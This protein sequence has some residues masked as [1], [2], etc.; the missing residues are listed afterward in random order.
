MEGRCHHFCG[1]ILKRRR[2]RG[3]E[4]R[5]KETPYQ[6]SL[7]VHTKMSCY[8]NWVGGNENSGK[9]GSASYGFYDGGI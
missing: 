1:E 4:R 7:V 3:R 8:L 6:N 2:E 5:K 9:P